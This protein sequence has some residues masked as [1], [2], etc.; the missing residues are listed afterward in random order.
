MRAS[1]RRRD[2]GLPSTVSPS[3]LRATRPREARAD[4]AR[5]AAGRL[6]VQGRRRKHG[7]TSHLLPMRFLVLGAAADRAPRGARRTATTPVR[8]HLSDWLVRFTRRRLRQPRPAERR[9]TRASWEDPLAA[10]RPTGRL[11]E[12]P[13]R[14]HVDQRLRLLGCGAALRRRPARSAHVYTRDPCGAGGGRSP[15]DQPTRWGAI[16]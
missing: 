7:P 16:R 15:D 4:G 13:R 10:P 12:P 6:M 2:H 1:A 14:H 3:V 8:H 11:R 9:R 5:F